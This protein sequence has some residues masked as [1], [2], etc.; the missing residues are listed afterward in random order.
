M[1][2]GEE[3]MRFRGGIEGEK[4]DYFFYFFVVVRL[5]VNGTIPSR[6]ISGRV[7]VDPTIRRGGKALPR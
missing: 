2:A 3:C 7:V 6:Q 1:D 4:V 5:G